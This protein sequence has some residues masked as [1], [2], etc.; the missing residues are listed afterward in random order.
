ML[1]I[2]VDGF[3]ILNGW[4]IFVSSVKLSTRI[5]QIKIIG[6]FD[7]GQFIE[8]FCVALIFNDNTLGILKVDVGAVKDEYLFLLAHGL[9]GN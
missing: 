7:M 1:Q 8:Y 6:W 3:E 9:V 4:G 5:L 2:D